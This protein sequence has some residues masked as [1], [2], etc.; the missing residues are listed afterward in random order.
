MIS[1]ND[2]TILKKRSEDSLKIILREIKNSSLNKSDYIILKK[3]AENNTLYNV[4]L[5][6]LFN[7]DEKRYIVEQEYISIIE[8]HCDFIE[9]MYL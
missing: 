9:S 2:L 7:N 6:E 8:E 1:K 5:A 3:L 4:F